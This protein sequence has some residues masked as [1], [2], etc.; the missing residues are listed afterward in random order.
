[1]ET[2]FFLGLMKTVVDLQAHPRC[3]TDAYQLLVAFGYSEV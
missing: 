2:I 1:M 3:G